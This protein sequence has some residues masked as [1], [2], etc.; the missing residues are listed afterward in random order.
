M[1]WSEGLT[2]GQRSPDW[3]ESLNVGTIPEKPWKWSDADVVFSAAYAD[4]YPHAESSSEASSNSSSSVSGGSTLSS[5]RESS[6]DR[7]AESADSVRSSA[8]NAIASGSSTP[9]NEAKQTTEALVVRSFHQGWDRTFE[10]HHAWPRPAI[11]N[12]SEV[13]IRNVAIGLNPVDFKS[14]VYKFGIA[15]LPWVLGRDVA[16][17]IEEVGPD[18]THFQPGDRVSNMHRFSLR[19][20]TH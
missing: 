15:A 19:N 7:L 2:S 1:A 4:D 16:G 12:P 17:V 14:V 3:L 18:V 10:L 5:P 8:T 13:L 11:S 6:L 9:S 20:P